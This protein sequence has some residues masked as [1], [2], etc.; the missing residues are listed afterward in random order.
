MDPDD[1]LKTT[2]TRG[3][4]VHYYVQMPFGLKN[5]ISTFQRLM[6]LTFAHQ[7]GHNVEAYVDDA[8]IKSMTFYE[9]LADLEETSQTLHVTNLS[10]IK[11]D[12]LSLWGKQVFRIHDL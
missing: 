7:M 3:D 6:E 2:F 9:H 4:V 10:S 5:A 11:K 1:A 8:I 12:L